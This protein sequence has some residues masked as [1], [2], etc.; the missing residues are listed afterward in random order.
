LNFTLRQI[1]DELSAAMEHRRESGR[2]LYEDILASE[3][4]DGRRI[5]AENKGAVAFIPFFAYGE[6]E[7]V[8]GEGRI[9]G[10]LF[11][12][13]TVGAAPD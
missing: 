11:R 3:A 13:R 7:G 4:R 10:L 6:L 1:G 9:R 12:K 5:V 2:N 8:L